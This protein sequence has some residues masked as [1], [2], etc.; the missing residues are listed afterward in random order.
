MKKRIVPIL[1][2]TLIVGAFGTAYALS[3]YLS[4]FNSTYGTTGTVLSSCT[5]CHPAGGGN[6]ASNLNN[7]AIDSQI[8]GM[9][10]WQSKG[11]IPTETDLRTLSKS[12]RRPFPVMRQAIRLPLMRC[13]LSSPHLLSHQRLLRSVYLSQPSLQW[14]TSA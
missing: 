5:L 1:I 3:S 6:N 4:S 11:G 10:S 12:M 9:T 14:T 7:F 8:V 13:Y 2:V